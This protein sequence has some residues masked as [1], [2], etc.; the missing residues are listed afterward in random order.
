MKKFILVSLDADKKP[1]RESVDLFELV[2]RSFMY[3]SDLSGVTESFD[4]LTEHGYKIIVESSQPFL[5][6]SALHEASIKEL[7]QKA[8][9]KFGGNKDEF[10]DWYKEERAKREQAGSYKP[11]VVPSRAVSS[12][13]SAGSVF[14]K[15]VT[16]GTSGT[17]YS[18][19]LR[20]DDAPAAPTTSPA[21]V[22]EYIKKV[23]NMVT[24]TGTVLA[25]LYEMDKD[26]YF[27]AMDKLTQV[28]QKLDE[29]YS[30]LV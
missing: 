13:V 1:L 8:K 20:T 27:A 16:P 3:K 9:E 28:Q 17:P 24:A 5:Y 10:N 15:N 21:V 14:E 6:E 12:P 4:I 19:R 22:Q 18:R 26:A 23:N 11:P 30:K 25:K 29:K 7:L 2:D